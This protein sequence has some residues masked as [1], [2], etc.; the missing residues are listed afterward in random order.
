MMTGL[1]EPLFVAHVDRPAVRPGDNDV[2]AG[3]KE[4]VARKE[5]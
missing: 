5:Q 3:V 4:G 2:A 1:I